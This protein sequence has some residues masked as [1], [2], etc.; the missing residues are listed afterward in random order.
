MYIF[1]PLA[2]ILSLLPISVC[3]NCSCHTHS[4]EYHAVLKGYLLIYNHKPKMV[5]AENSGIEQS[6]F[7]ITCCAVAQACVKGDTSFLWEPRVTFVFSAHPWRSDRPTNLHAKWLKRRGFT[8]GCA[9]CSKNRY[10][11]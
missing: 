4:C 11:S 10:M 8:Q 7:D 6:I 9:L 3:F 1:S 5:I 2:C